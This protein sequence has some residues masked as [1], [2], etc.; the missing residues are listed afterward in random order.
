MASGAGYFDGDKYTLSFKKEGFQE[1]IAT[2]DTEVN[3]WY[4]GNILFGGIIGMLIVDPSTGA[5]FKLPESFGA[6]LTVQTCNG[7]KN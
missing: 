2:L 4:F 1:K 6:D 7:I 3:G 5:M